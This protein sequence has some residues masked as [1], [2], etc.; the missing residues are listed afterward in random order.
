MSWL[1]SFMSVARRLTLM[2]QHGGSRSLAATNERAS[3]RIYTTVYGRTSHGRKTQGSIAPPIAPS[4]AL[5]CALL[6][7]PRDRVQVGPIG[8]VKPMMVEHPL[9]GKVISVDA[10]FASGFETRRA[11]FPPP[12]I[13][14]KTPVSDYPAIWTSR[15]AFDPPIA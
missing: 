9:E 5:K 4:M 6:C 1:W 15:G 14:V 12:C 13:L 3:E 8:P 10:P 2:Q 7:T 11:A